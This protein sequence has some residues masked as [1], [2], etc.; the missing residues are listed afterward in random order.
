METFRDVYIC[1]AKFKYYRPQ[2]TFFP[3][4]LGTDSL[5][6]FFSLLRATHNSG[7]LDTLE[8]ANRSQWIHAV[9][10]IYKNHPDWQVKHNGRKR[11]NTSLDDSNSKEW[12]QDILKLGDVGISD[13]WNKGMHV[14]SLKL[15]ESKL[16]QRNELD[17]HKM[18]DTSVSI[19]KPD[20][21]RVGVICEE[22]DWS[23]P[24]PNEIAEEWWDRLRNRI[25]SV[26]N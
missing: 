18:S 24:L 4:R 14:A 11:R 17:F 16:F 1:A 23:M 15:L 19:L 7:S 2:E 3:F 20:G 12:N 22:Y 6:N 9:D 26:N 21:K 5:E 8:I 10:D 13:C 25:F